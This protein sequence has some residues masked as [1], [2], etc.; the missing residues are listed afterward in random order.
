MPWHIMVP[1]VEPTVDKEKVLVVDD[2]EAIREGRA[3]YERGE[4]MTL[5]EY[6]RNHP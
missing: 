1:S 3:A 4:G 2:E 5:E 6:R